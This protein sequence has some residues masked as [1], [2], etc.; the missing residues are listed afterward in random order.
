MVITQQ[1]T[2]ILHDSQK[3]TMAVASICNGTVI[4]HILA[5]QALRIVCLTDLANHRKQVTVGMNLPSKSLGYKDIVKVE[6][7]ELTP[8]QVNQI[9]IFAPQATIS[10]I[11][12]FQIFHKYKV[13]LPETI[14]TVITCPNPRCISNHDRME[15][16]FYIKKWK[17]AI[18][19]QCRFCRK[20]FSQAEVETK[21]VL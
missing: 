5:G 1:A 7:W 16:F 19:L 13:I 4:D 3:K 20:T 10:I 9:S 8:S 21:G 18:H 2:E 17:Q 15:T 12:N 14:T 6:A 11:R